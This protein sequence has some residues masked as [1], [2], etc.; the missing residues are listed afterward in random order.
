LLFVLQYTWYFVWLQFK[1]KLQ[2]G[3]VDIGESASSNKTQDNHPVTTRRHTV[4][5]GNGLM[6]QVTY[7]FHFVIFEPKFPL[8]YNINGLILV[9]L[10]IYL[11]I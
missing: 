1:N 8:F 2:Y 10:L 6:T 4:G 7:Y 5:P 9:Y 3:D 11:N